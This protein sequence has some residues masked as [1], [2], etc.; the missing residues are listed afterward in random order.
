VLVDASPSMAP[1]GHV[2]RLLLEAQVIG[3]LDRLRASGE[4][5]PA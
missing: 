3:A 1:W 2:N 5:P 4:R